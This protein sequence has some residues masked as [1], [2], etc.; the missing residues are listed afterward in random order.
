[1]RSDNCRIGCTSDTS[2]LPSAACRSLACLCARACDGL[3]SESFSSALRLPAAPTWLESPPVVREAARA[4]GNIYT[5]LGSTQVPSY[6][7]NMRGSTRIMTDLSHRESENTS[8]S[9]PPSRAERPSRQGTHKVKYYRKPLAPGSI[10]SVEP[11]GLP[12]GSSAA[13][14]PARA[15]AR[16]SRG[17]FHFLDCTSKRHGI[18]VEL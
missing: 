4:T 17:R 13:L 3:A 7:E 9:L 5:W 18:E 10:E 8:E 2:R 16:V 6:S 12:G 15:V 11:A 14:I 1:M